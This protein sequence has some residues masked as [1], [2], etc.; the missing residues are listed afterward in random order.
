MLSLASFTSKALDS[1]PEDGLSLLGQLNPDQSP[2][3]IFK[4]ERFQL[5]RPWT[6]VNESLPQF[7]EKINIA[8]KSLLDWQKFLPPYTEENHCSRILVSHAGF[9]SPSYILICMNQQRITLATIICHALSDTYCYI[10][11][12]CCFTANV[13][14][15]VYLSLGT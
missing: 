14:D 3:S 12:L 8:P 6:K 7:S 10:M 1:H 5:W 9:C 4:A 15:E 13:G 2:L 11:T